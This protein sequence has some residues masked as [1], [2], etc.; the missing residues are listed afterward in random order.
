MNP[1]N[2]VGRPS[3]TEICDP[4][5]NEWVLLVE[6]ED[7]NDRTDATSVAQATFERGR[8]PKESTTSRW[9]SSPPR[10]AVA[11]SGRRAI[12]GAPLTLNPVLALG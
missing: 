8:E 10:T 6:I 3:W 4:Y 5:R 7:E 11:G 9:A 12:M 1:T 2:H